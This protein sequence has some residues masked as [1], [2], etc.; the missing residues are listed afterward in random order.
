MPCTIESDAQVVVNLIPNGVFPYFEVGLIV[1]DIC[2]KLEMLP[3]CFVI[4]APR[5]ANNVAHCP[6]KL[7]LSFVEDRF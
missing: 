7:D 5:R 3:S 1:K 4:F 2:L 6:A